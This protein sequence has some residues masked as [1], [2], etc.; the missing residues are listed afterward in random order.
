MPYPDLLKPLNLGFSQLKNRVVM[1]SMHT[2][3]EETDNGFE[4]VA[5]FY[6]E[7]AAGGVG[8]II[9]GGIA[10]NIEGRLAPNRAVMATEQDVCDHQL[11]TGAVH[12]QDGKIC[13]QILHAG[14]YGYTPAQ[15][16]P[17]AIQAPI[18]PYTPKALTEDQVLKQIS[19]FARSAKLA[20][21]AGYDGVEIMGS[22]GYLINQFIVK[23]TNTRDDRWGGSF[24]N[25]MRFP[26]EVVKAT[27]A[28]V[29]VEFII[30]FR[31]SLIDLIVDGSDA[32][33]VIRLAVELEAQGVN[34]INTGIGWHESRVP[35]I[36]TCVPRGA[37]THLSHNIKQHISIPVVTSNRINTPQLANELIA[38]GAADLVSMARPFL[39]DSQFVSKASQNKAETINTCIGCNQACLDHIFVNK[40]ATCILNPRACHETELILKPA[41]TVKNLA[42]VGAG[43]AGMAFAA[44][45]SE[46]GHRVTLFEAAEQLGGQLNLASMIPGKQEFLETLRYFKQRLSDLGVITKLNTLATPEKL[47]AFDEV[48]VAT[49]IVPRVPD[50]AGIE[51]DKV[52]SYLDV[53]SNKV[54]VGSKVAIIGAGG[55]GFDTALFLADNQPFYDKKQHRALGGQTEFVNRWGIDL[56]L[57]SRGGLVPP[58]HDVAKR[59]I[60]LLQRR[61]RKPGA[62]LGKTTAWIHRQH[63]KDKEVKMLIGVS[64]ERIDQQGLHISV[65]GKHRILEVDHVVICGGQ[66][67]HNTLASQITDRPCHLIG[68]AKRAAGLDVQRAI[69]EAIELAQTI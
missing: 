67:E 64:Y 36:A 57:K 7:R 43:A 38:S 29:G 6:A 47:T 32:D 24:E 53:L 35:T 56:S 26:L 11:I 42:V 5:A 69:K 9:T 65:R 2:N 34:I 12:R 50:I 59:E 8:L 44:Y 33:E 37:F 48:V 3:L 55:I 61:L 19:D 49:G 52:V 62:D 68:G 27:R 18:S 25:R 45:A 14:R 51:S 66:L 15:V 22:E 63:L 54:A 21:Q 4:K 1:G 20:Q 10:P 58:R 40:I 17:S 28:L 39:A 46:R 13:M 16:A 30:I 31:L 60:Y 41:D 23:A